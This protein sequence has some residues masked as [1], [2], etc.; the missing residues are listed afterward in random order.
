MISDLIW[1]ITVCVLVSAAPVVWPLGKRRTQTHKISRSRRW[2]SCPTPNTLRRKSWSTVPANRW[3][4]LRSSPSKTVTMTTTWR[5]LPAAPPDRSW[6]IARPHRAAP[7]PSPRVWIRPLTRHLSRHPT[8]GWRAGTG[9]GTGAPPS[10]WWGPRRAGGTVTGSWSSCRP[11]RAGWRDGANR[12]RKRPKSTSS[13]RKV[14]PHIWSLVCSDGLE[15]VGWP[16][17]I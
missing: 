8:P 16:S 12:W 1:L 2:R 14:R 6:P 9:R 10:R 4:R 17:K 5:W 11:R 15:I 13:Q 7:R 3:T